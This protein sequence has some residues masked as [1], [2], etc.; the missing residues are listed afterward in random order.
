MPQRASEIEGDG[1]ETRVPFH[2]PQVTLPTLSSPIILVLR[3]LITNDGVLSRNGDKDECT[4]PSRGAQQL[5]IGGWS[6]SSDT[7]Y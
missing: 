3:E 1:C 2:I 7:V 4:P 5:T 6:H